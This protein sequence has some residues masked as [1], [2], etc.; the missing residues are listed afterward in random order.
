MIRNL[1]KYFKNHEKAFLILLFTFG[2]ILRSLFTYYIY[3][4]EGKSDW[5]DDG[6]YLYLGEQIADGNWYTG[7][8][9]GNMSFI[10]GPV[11]P[12]IIALFILLFKDPIIPFFIYN[13]IITSLM[14]P[15]FYYL[16]KEVFNEKVGWFLA[17]WGIFF[18]EAYKYSPHILKEPT[19]FLFVPLTLLLLIKSIKGGNSFKSLLFASLSFAWLIHTDE[20]FIVYSPVFIVFFLFKKPFITRTFVMQTSLWT[21]LV[22]LLML[23]WTI[24]NFLVF[25]QV[26]LLTP[27]TTAITSKFWGEDISAAAA[28]FSSDEIRERTIDGRY[29]SAMDFGQQYGISPREFGKIE[30]R[31]RAF[32]NFW[33]PTFSK[34]TYIQYGYRIQKWSFRH[35]ALSMLYYGI[36]LPFYI[37][38]TF[39]LFRRKL[40]LPLFIGIIPIIHS[41]MHAYMVWPLE[42][43][44]SPI[45]FIIVMI[46]IWAAMQLYPL[47]RK[48]FPVSK[49]NI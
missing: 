25:D 41:L 20:R 8:V 37:I 1:I 33:Q 36:F 31:L 26:V 13:I 34:P 27:R 18:I 45:T 24:R 32:K 9:T 16:G 15:V 7:V 17:I 43:Y 4:T 42:R 46:G 22:V 2:L 30:A 28:H 3:S 21:L 11:I 49:Q 40:Y 6:L 10:V 44:R 14:I 12:V 48:T 39:I 29:D 5:G 47:L 23:P 35:N 19:L 38:G